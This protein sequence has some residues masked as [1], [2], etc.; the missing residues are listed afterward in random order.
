MK[1]MI[2]RRSF[3]QTLCSTAAVGAMSVCSSPA[4]SA[5]FGETAVAGR[6]IAY[7]EPFDWGPGVTRTILALDKYVWP[8]SVNAASFS[9]KETKPSFDFMTGQVST[10]TCNRPVV[11]A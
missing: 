4:A 7:L 2:A 10:L 5:A 1:K 6:Q 3:L 9:V 11:A 8:Q